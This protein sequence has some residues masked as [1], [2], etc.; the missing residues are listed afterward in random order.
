[1]AADEDH[2]TPDVE[3]PKDT[4]PEAVLDLDGSR[5]GTLSQAGKISHFTC[6]N[7]PG[8]DIL[9]QFSTAETKL[10]RI[11]WGIIEAAA[12]T[13]TQTKVLSDNKNTVAALCCDNGTVLLYS[14][15]TQTVV[16][17]LGG[18]HV[19]KGAVRDFQ[20]EAAGQFG[21]S[22]GAD[23]RLVKWDL[24]TGKEV[25]RA[26]V[27]VA[28]PNRL[29]IVNWAGRIAVG[30]S[31]I[32]ILD[33]TDLK[34]Q[35]SLPRC[36]K[37]V[38]RLIFSIDAEYLFVVTTGD[39]FVNVWHVAGDK[40]DRARDAP[41]ATLALSHPITHLDVCHK[42]GHVLAGTAQRALYAWRDVV[43]QIKD[44]SEAVA[45]TTAKSNGA[46]PTGAK[47]KFLAHK[48]DLTVKLETTTRDIAANITRV[49]ILDA[50][51]HAKSK[52]L[53][54]YVATGLHLRP[55]FSDF[56]IV[57]PQNQWL[58]AITH[59]CTTSVKVEIA[60]SGNSDFSMQ[61][62]F[63]SQ[64]QT[65]NL[66]VD[67]GASIGIGGD[68]LVG[69]EYGN[70]KVAAAARAKKDD[71]T[72]EERL[73]DIMKKSGESTTPTDATL[74]S[75]SAITSA[76][77]STDLGAAAGSL[78]SLLAQGL[79]TSDYSIINRVLS[80]SRYVSQTVALLPPQYVIPLV[81]ELVGRIPSVP[82]TAASAAKPRVSEDKVTLRTLFL[83]VENL[84]ALHTA[85]LVSLPGMDQHLRALYQALDTRCRLIPAVVDLHSR[86]ELVSRQIKLQR[87]A[88]EVEPTLVRDEMIAVDEDAIP[89]RAWAGYLSEDSSDDE[90]AHDDDSD[91]YA[92]S[93]DGV[94]SD[95]E[96]AVVDDLDNLGAT[97]K[98]QR[99]VAND[100]DEESDE[101][102][103][104]ESEEDSD[105]ESEE[106]SDEDSD[107]APENHAEGM[108][109]STDESS[110][111]DSEEDSDEDQ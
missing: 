49:P 58:T 101:D 61:R 25:K 91:E 28:N 18:N 40:Q 15:T 26:E 84:L 92:S 104:E 44:D 39:R 8:G 75:G 17:S 82:S 66:L 21:Y 10:T 93:I 48:P 87:L 22:L 108:E 62:K 95:D 74:A 32:K 67:S 56:A 57:N 6:M 2:K 14:P 79:R 72:I 13:Q 96:E 70:E 35:V 80:S 59:Q 24:V 85:Y 77:G 41:A 98:A 111:D 103:D 19:H 83:W 4:V 1:M 68:Y 3:R 29:A 88:G 12:S 69:E 86:L 51:L 31:S 73:R 53:S 43:K 99:S 94:E 23:G 71:R 36:P 16:R 20:F 100:S 89:V 102:P 55:F 46:K 106:D 27:D 97:G 9:A 50:R 37:P 76:A 78:S 52:V 45:T 63:A 107:M 33:T 64:R 105:E 30:G 110:D 60:R 81:H 38:H 11:A 109:V 54:I 65:Q 47:S 7:L 5:F 42:A 90:H 34:V